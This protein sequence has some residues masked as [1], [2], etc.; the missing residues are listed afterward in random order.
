MPAL[1]G[2]KTNCL[3]SLTMNRRILLGHSSLL[4]LCFLAC[5]NHTEQI[6][7]YDTDIASTRDSVLANEYDGQTVTIDASGE[8]GNLINGGQII[9]KH[10]EFDSR[11]S[12]T[13][14]D[15]C[16]PSD[17]TITHNKKYV[18]IAARYFDDDIRILLK[19]DNGV[20]GWTSIRFTSE[21]REFANLH[22][23]EC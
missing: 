22:L 9:L 7:Y 23:T 20:K 12:P 17:G 2:L 18:I 21:F 19:G 10:R 16:I 13:E 11:R 14:F 5:T 3:K 8:F 4:L 6:A 1:E 15:G